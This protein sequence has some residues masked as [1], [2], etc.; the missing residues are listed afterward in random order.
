MNRWLAA[1]LLVALALVFVLAWYFDRT[2][3]LAARDLDP[4]TFAIFRQITRLGRSEWYLI[5]SGIGATLGFVMT[6]R[7][8]GAAWHRFTQRCVWVFSAVAVSGLVTN[9]LKIVF[10]RPRP[11]LLD[12]DYG[13]GWF[14]FGS[15]WAS[16]P[17]GH[18]N[19]AFA[20]ALA[21][22]ALW[23]AWRRP[24]LVVAAI[25]AASRVVIGAHY[26]SD[27]LAGAAVAVVTT[28]LLQ[29]WFRRKGWGDLPPQ[30][31]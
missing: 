3:A 17:S 16:F 25:V 28:L 19:T 10:G 15:D 31:E 23:P 9:A 26:L 7:G 6:R 12:S 29:R 24:L 1:L 8:A 27:T 18:S 14:R 20:I 13:M 4:T 2:L 11:R 21:L 22:A 30:P 5:P